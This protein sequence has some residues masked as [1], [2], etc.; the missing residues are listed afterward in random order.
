M[1]RGERDEVH[2][3]VS[4]AHV[5]PAAAASRA[6]RICAAIYVLVR[7]GSHCRVPSYNSWPMADVVAKGGIG[8]LR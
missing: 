5:L 6:S 1:L 7:H 8:R 3:A 4:S 2:A